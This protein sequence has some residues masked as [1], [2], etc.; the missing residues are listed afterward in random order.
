[1]E[2]TPLATKESAISTS[3]QHKGAIDG[4]DYSIYNFF[5]ANTGFAI[6]VV[7]GIVTVSLF[8]FRYASKLYNYAYLRFWDVDIAYARQEDSEV[9]YIALGV[10]LYYC[11]LMLSQV[12]LGNTTAVYSH[13]NRV[14]LAVKVFQ[15]KLT[16]K[17]RANK[18]I[19]RRLQEQLRKETRISRKRQ[20][21]E[22]ISNV[23]ARILALRTSRADKKAIY[24]Y[25][26]TLFVRTS[27]SFVASLLLCIVGA[28]ILSV[29]YEDSIKKEMFFVLTIA[30]VSLGL[31]LFILQ[32]RPKIDSD[33]DV[34]KEIE[35]FLREVNEDKTMLFP[36][37]AWVKKGIK[38]FLTNKTMG[39]M[40][41]QYLIT[42]FT[43]IMVL[44]SFGT[45]HAKELREFRVWT[46]GHSTYAIIY[47]NGT[48][49]IMEAIEIQGNSA[50]IDTS[51]QRIIKPDDLSYE[52]YIFETIKITEND[53]RKN[54]TTGINSETN[55][56]PRS[57][58]DLRRS[59]LQ[60]VCHSY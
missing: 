28:W 1:M 3:R 25:K 24:G 30:P 48:E 5:R 41:M 35:Q 23:E 20:L 47:D 16:R 9:F 56:F 40:V 6:A 57:T 58:I 60:M 8:I 21:V 26:T 52:I 12:L 11:L 50:T 34:I 37:E 46:D 13:Q 33:Q 51:S 53:S 39:V 7:S 18:K 29:N 43:C 2:T 27:I 32:K 22:R 4:P 19:K 54:G 36:V 55:S 15:K 45:R 38:Y 42:M 17:R 31:L 14:Y 44:S 49:I 10:F 59:K